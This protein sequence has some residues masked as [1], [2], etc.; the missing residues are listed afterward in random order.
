MD[1]Y[2]LFRRTAVGDA[3]PDAPRI[4]RWVA[5]KEIKATSRPSAL[6]AYY[7]AVTAWGFDITSQTSGLMDHEGYPV[8]AHRSSSINFEHV[9]IDGNWQEAS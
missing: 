8:M 5:F 2:T 1:T 3:R 6:R 4:R 7:G 9:D